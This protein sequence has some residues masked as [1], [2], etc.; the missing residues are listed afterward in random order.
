MRFLISIGMTMIV[1]KKKTSTIIRAFIAKCYFWNSK[2]KNCNLKQIIYKNTKIS[3]TDDGKG[4][5]VL[6]LHGF[7]EN[8]TMW[9]KYVSAL[10]KN[11][12]IITIDLLGHGETACVGYVHSMED[13]AD[14]L[15]SL[16]QH[17]RIKKVALIGHSMGGYIS[18][19]FAEMYPD[20][21]RGI[22]LLNSTTRPDSDEKK[23]NRDRAITAVKQNYSNFIRM[24]ITNLFNEDTREKLKN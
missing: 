15:H 4:A 17:L 9:D 8:K 13:Q 22:V 10:S 11:Y 23:A 1:A 5:A 20:H 16:M 12:R 6:L 24:S 19:A 3:F 21:V 18:L 14:M 2:P 7:L